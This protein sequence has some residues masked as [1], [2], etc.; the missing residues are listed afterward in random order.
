MN[1]IKQFFKKIWYKLFT[2]RREKRLKKIEEQKAL[3]KL[4]EDFEKRRKGSIARIKEIMYHPKIK[5]VYDERERVAHLKNTLMQGKKH[6]LMIQ[7][8]MKGTPFF[9]EPEIVDIH[10]ERLDRNGKPTLSELKAIHEKNAEFN[11]DKQ[12]IKADAL[13]FSQ[14]SI[15]SVK[16]NQLMN[17]PFQELS[18]NEIRSL[19]RDEEIMR[20]TEIERD[21]KAMNIAEMFKDKPMEDV[22]FPKDINIDDFPTIKKILGKNKK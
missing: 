1:K 14:S 18:L 7:K 2:E 6:V 3:K 16:R 20:L 21:M 8:Y 9:Y 12:A 4:I 17:K 22:D 10:N 13:L 19:R 11:L 15:N 5:Y